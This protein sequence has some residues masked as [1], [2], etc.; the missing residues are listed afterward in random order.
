M[1]PG[2]G[3]RFAAAALAAIALICGAPAAVAA[4]ANP[5]LSAQIRGVND[6]AMK[7]EALRMASL[8]VAVRLHGNIAETTLTARFENPS[9]TILEGDFGFDMPRGSVVTGYAL[10]VGLTMV[11]GVLL[12][13]RKA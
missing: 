9:N 2:W 7:S 12:D 5:Q 1:M 11:D 8:D 4:P 3:W 10:D 6:A 13:Q